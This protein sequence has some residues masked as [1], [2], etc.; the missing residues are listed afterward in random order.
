MT[1]MLWL[2]LVGLAAVPPGACGEVVA[3]AATGFTVKH[4]VTVAK[5][6]AET[7][8]ALGR[9][10][11]WWG[12]DHTWSGDAANLSLDLK[13]G[14]CWCEALP[15]GGVQHMTVVFAQ[16]GQ[17]LRLTGG[18]GPLQQLAVTGVMTWQFAEQNG[19]T[20]LTMTYVVAGAGGLDG[21][22]APVDGVLTL[23]ME[24]LKRF[25]ETGNADAG[26]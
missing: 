24:R 11:S 1:R 7:W 14:G 9:L 20:S 5:P 4:A 15:G 21:V 10:G 25:A 8:H 13:P 12:K 19:K 16:P 23:Q 17:L 6:A 18:L 3:S 2:T 22:A 26:R